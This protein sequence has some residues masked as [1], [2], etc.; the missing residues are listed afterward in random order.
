MQLTNFLLL[1][2]T[3]TIAGHIV[4]ELHH[5]EFWAEQIHCAIGGLILAWLTC[6][7]CDCFAVQV[8]T[9]AVALFT[10]QLL[11]C[12]HQTPQR[13]TVQRK[14]Q[15]RRARYTILEAVQYAN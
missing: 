10:A 4:I 11:W 5:R 13:K 6:W 8:L 15:Y 1:I 2:F 9:L 12:G 14:R 3:M 7:A